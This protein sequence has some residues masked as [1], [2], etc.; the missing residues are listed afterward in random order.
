[1][2]LTIV[3][4][5]LFNSVIL[6]LSGKL[7]HGENA[8]SD[9]VASLLKDGKLRIVINLRG[10][11]QMDSFGLGQLFNVW[12]MAE[13]KGGKISFMRPPNRVTQHLNMLKLNEIF[14]ISG[15]ETSTMEHLSHPKQPPDSGK[16]S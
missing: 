11:T 2:P 5:S 4:R 9:Q 1:M 12:S 16:K 6:D 13:S 15:D 3:P 14:Q 8:L 7:C 10:I